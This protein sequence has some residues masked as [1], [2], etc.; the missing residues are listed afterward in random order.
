MDRTRAAEILA[1]FLA[2]GPVAYNDL[3]DAESVAL[4]DWT[5]A[6]R[7]SHG[8]LTFRDALYAFSDGEA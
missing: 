7:E 5:R 6:R 3:S 4:R 2:I 1:S 8:L